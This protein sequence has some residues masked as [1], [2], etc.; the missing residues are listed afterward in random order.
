[1]CVFNAKV[2]CRSPKIGTAY[3]PYFG[4]KICNKKAESTMCLVYGRKL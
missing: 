2:V 4:L 3:L 1:M